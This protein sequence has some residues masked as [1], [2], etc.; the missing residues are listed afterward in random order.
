[1]KATRQDRINWLLANQKEWKS[2][3]RIHETRTK[4]II[5]KMKQASVLSEKTNWYDVNLTSLVN[6]ARR[7]RRRLQKYGHYRRYS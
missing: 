3:P 1:M 2:Y 5:E 6:D 7:K 4:V